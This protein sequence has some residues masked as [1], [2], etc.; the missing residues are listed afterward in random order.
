VNRHNERIRAFTLTSRQPIE[1]AVFDLFLQTLGSIEP[2]RLLRLKGL[3]AL[4]ERPDEPMVVHGVQHV[5]HQPVRLARWP[6]ADR[7]TRLVLI[8]EDLSEDQVRTLW[9]S[10][11]NV[12]A[13][14]RPDRQ[15]L[16]DNPLKITMGGLLG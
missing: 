12:P 2:G 14:D 10:L 15:A 8:V 3:V 6:D 7:S 5:V 13:P 16:R 1:A 4:A 9:A 11:S